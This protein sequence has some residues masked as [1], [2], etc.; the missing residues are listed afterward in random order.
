MTLGEKL[1]ALRD[2]R[3]WS[4]QE[5][6]REA[7]VRQSLISELERGKKKDTTGRNLR[8]LARAL[9][10]SVDYLAGMFNGDPDRPCPGEEQCL[11]G[12]TLPPVTTILE[13]TA[14]GEEYTKV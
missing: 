6:A 4:Q 13:R 8:H 5:L 7:S 3:G 9:H 10:V 2:A 11:D 12:L 1:K 14:D